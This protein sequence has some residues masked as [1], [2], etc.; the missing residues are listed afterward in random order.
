MSEC[1]QNILKAEAFR[2]EDAVLVMSSCSAKTAA[3]PILL[4]EIRI[5][6]KPRFTLV[7]VG[8]LLMFRAVLM[9]KV[10]VMDLVVTV[11]SIQGMTPKVWRY[12]AV[13]TPKLSSPVLSGS[14]IENI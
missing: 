7:L 12:S 3:M 11:Q 10:I 5:P 8:I 1:L 2:F 9:N 6:L 13:I 4:L 14:V